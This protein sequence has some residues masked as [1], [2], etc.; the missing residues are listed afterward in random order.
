MQ[1]KLIR[2][3]PIRVR[4]VNVESWHDENAYYQ[5]FEQSVGSADVLIVTLKS[6]RR[7]AKDTRI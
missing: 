2:E 5:K 3:T 4:F 7:D 1:S 6:N